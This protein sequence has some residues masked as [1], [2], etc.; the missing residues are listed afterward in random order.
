MKLTPG[1]ERRIDTHTLR[2]ISPVKPL[3]SSGAP[4]LDANFVRLRL[5]RCLDGGPIRPH[6][7]FTVIFT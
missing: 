3:A 5:V 1:P 7:Q 6:R 2:E 4:F